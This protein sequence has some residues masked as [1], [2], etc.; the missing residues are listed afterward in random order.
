MKSGQHDVD[1]PRNQAHQHHG[2]DQNGR[3]FSVPPS[4]A[5]GGDGSGARPFGVLRMT[6]STNATLRTRLRRKVVDCGSRFCTINSKSIKDC[7][8]H[9]GANH[10][11][12]MPA[13]CD[14]HRRIVIHAAA[15]VAVQQ[16]GGDGA[17]K[18]DRRPVRPPENRGGRE[19]QGAGDEQRRSSGVLRFADVK[20]QGKR[21]KPRARTD[22]AKGIYGVYGAASEN[23]GTAF[24][25]K[26]PGQHK[27]K[28]AQRNT[29]SV[30][31]LCR[32]D[33]LFFHHSPASLAGSTTSP[34]S[35]S[36]ARQIRPEIPRLT[37]LP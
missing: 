29:E 7:R 12:R 36:S 28:K 31:E 11:A 16:Q 23:D 35:Q 15:D 20:E 14:M 37:G 21:E 18:E 19:A 4:A 1:H 9:A 8:P 27:G 34:I 13:P 22:K 2:D 3:Y 24:V 32:C 5:G 30:K 6:Y 10:P 25:D 26:R 33:L 17:C